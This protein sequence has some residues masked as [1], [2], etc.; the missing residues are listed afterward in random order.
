VLTKDL[1]LRSMNPAWAATMLT[2]V[3]TFII[4][5]ILYNYLIFCPTWWDL[6]RGPVWVS[7]NSTTEDTSSST[8]AAVPSTWS[9]SWHI[10]D[11]IIRAPICTFPTAMTAYAS[12]HRQPLAPLVLLFRP[13]FSSMSLW[14]VTIWSLFLS[15][16]GT[17]CQMVMW[18]CDP[19]TKMR[20]FPVFITIWV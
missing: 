12:W 16:S 3:S 10:P 13:P 19:K 7:M 1:R 14:Q 17:S 2:T 11:R 6:I 18:L 20:N 9:S 4:F 8:K 5:N 15:W